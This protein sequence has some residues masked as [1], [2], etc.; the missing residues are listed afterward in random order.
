MKTSR[1]ISTI[2][3]NTDDWLKNK[4]NELVKAHKISFWA[5]ITHKPEADELKEHKHVYVEPNGQIDTMN[6]TDHLKE[7]DPAHPDNPLCVVRW[8]SSKDDDW[9]LYV[10]HD[11]VYLATK[12]LTKKYHYAPDEFNS[13]DELSLKDMIYKAQH[14]SAYAKQK[15]IMDFLDTGADAS[16]LAYHGFMPVGQAVQMSAFANAYAHGM[17][18]KEREAEQKRIAE[19]MERK[20][21]EALSKPKV[22]PVNRTKT[23]LKA[24]EAKKGTNIQYE[25]VDGQENPFLPQEEG[26]KKTRKRKKAD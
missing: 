5:Y 19:E 6:L 3:Y 7:P 11:E 9:I 16:D 1:P 8:Q 12:G 22:P 25:F 15:R 2:S 4:L 13:S 24:P 14:E 21:Q 26:K 10:L 18:K 17:K 23:P 20:K